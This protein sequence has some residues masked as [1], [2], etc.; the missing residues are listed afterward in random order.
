[1]FRTRLQL[2]HFHKLNHKKTEMPVDSAIREPWA[3]KIF[4]RYFDFLVAA[5]TCLQHV[6]AN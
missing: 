6:N 5:G 2:K 4:L 3:L 1:M